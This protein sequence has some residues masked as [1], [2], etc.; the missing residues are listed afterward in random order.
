MRSS[1]AELYVL[2]N[3]SIDVTLNVA[4][5]P[6]AGETL[7]ASGIVR[8]PGGKG[9]N[10]AVVAARTG[11][12]VHFCAPIGTEPETAMLHAALARESFASLRLIAAA[13]PT[14][15]STLVVAAGGENL[16]ISTGD[17]AD[18]LTPEL[19]ADF[20]R[21]MRPQDWLLVQGNLSEPTTWAAVSRAPNIIFNTAPI[22]WISP[23]ILHAATIVIANQVEASQITASPD[24]TTPLGG[25]T[26]IVTLGAEGC[27][28]HH[29][30]QT[31]HFPAARIT[32][33]DSTGAGDTF[34]G[35]L[36]A[37]CAAGTDLPTA[38]THAQ[39][40]AALAVSRPGCFAALPRAEELS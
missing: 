12:Q 20:V 31:Q 15:L 36:A 24:P 6:L 14:D 5:L 10:Q 23:R 18:A 40:A 30:G 3:A 25:Q 33:I 1:V 37:H 4:R 11:A 22:R 38:I 27:L 2:G 34:C 19:A 21:P 35:V 7:M 17:C 28:L 39:N 26:S 9:L 16:I 8:A 13:L 29:N 32:A